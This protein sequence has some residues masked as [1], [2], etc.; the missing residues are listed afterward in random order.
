VTRARRAG[1]ALAAL[2]LALAIVEALS[3]IA[4]AAVEDAR[5]P[6]PAAA[7]AAERA[8]S[9]PAQPAPAPP[10]EDRATDSA[11][12]QRAERHRYWTLH[13]YVGI[14]AAATRSP[15]SRSMPTASSTRGSRCGSARPIA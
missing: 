1:F 5:V 2:A 6:A 12:A 15:G 9:A 8:D 7:A 4:L 13:P 3:W 14:P 11:A 10:P